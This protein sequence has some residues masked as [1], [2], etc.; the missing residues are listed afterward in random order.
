MLFNSFTF[1]IFLSLVFAVYW[2]FAGAPVR[3]Q[4][5]VLLVAAY[6][7]YGWWDWR[8]LLLLFANCLVDWATGIWLERESAPGRR[9]LVL[10]VSLVA[11]L[12]ALAVFKYYNFF[13]DQVVA[14]L[15]VFGTTVSPRTLNVILPVG[16]SF[17]TFQ[18][19]SYTIDIY[20]GRLRATRD[21][22][23]FLT[24]HS[25]FPQLVAGPIERA[26]S[27]LPQCLAPRTFDAVTAADGLR[28]MLGGLV[29]KVVI[30]DRLAPIV[31][32]TFRHHASLS[33]P[34]LW[35]G[36]FFFSIQ[37][38]CDFSGYTDIAIGTARLFGF[39]LTR[40]FA[41]PYFSRDIAEFWRR[42]HISL[43]TWFRDYLYI[44]LGGN[45]GGPGRT[46]RAVLITFGLSGL[47]HGA[48]WTFVVWGLLN[49]CYYLPI[50]LAKKQRRFTDTP[51]AGRLVPSVGEAARIGVT[52]FATTI[53][54]VFFRA[55][56]I[57]GALSYLRGMALAPWSVA[58]LWRFAVPTALC[59]GLL[60]VEWFQRDKE[61]ALDIRALPR[62]ARWAIYYSAVTLLFWIGNTGS[63]PFIYFQF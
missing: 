6:V 54:W 19:L 31:D 43:S 4:N 59:L 51:A 60:S 3:F 7:F 27:L 2:A 40:N 16:V 13:A 33:A 62:P 21:L 45:R 44:P 36:A 25:F 49:G 9:T 32:E 46:L 53:A 38:Y 34:T 61:H 18:S 11:N 8:F 63:V 37:I 17:Y 57:G 41:F 10:G 5:L 48:N 29:K 12:G 30:A 24:F 28:Q 1:A 35:I 47:W 52:F 20:R 50:L 14:L 22:L 42:W 55:S 15:A 58:H 56:T 39:R 26:T 23:G